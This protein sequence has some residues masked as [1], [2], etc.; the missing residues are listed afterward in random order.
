MSNVRGKATVAALAFVLVVAGCSKKTASPT[1]SGSQPPLKIGISLSFT[2]DFADPGAA[3]QRGYELWAQNVNAKG[4]ILGRQVQL[5]IVDD[6]SSTNTVVSNYESLITKD[7]VDL[8]LGPFSTLLTA[9][10]ATRANR[11]GYSF[12]EPAGGGPLVF[13]AKLPNVFFAQPAPVVSCG[14]PFVNFIASLPADQR[15]TTAAYPELDD[16]FAAPIAE[17]MRLCAKSRIVEADGKV[18]V[19]SSDRIAGAV[20]GPEPRLSSWY[21]S[22]TSTLSA[23][24]ACRWSLSCWRRKR[25]RLSV[26]PGHQPPG[27]LDVTQVLFTEL[28][29]ECYLFRA[30]AQQ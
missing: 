3:A 22:S 15:P 4:G 14:D 13:D 21:Q 1:P 27:A 7:K 19:E 9:P 29:P 30:D 26:E 17:P 8:V 10:A 28:L 25:G 11:Y 24:C 5:Q 12:I 2:G 23:F 18:L 20:A 6:G 16:P